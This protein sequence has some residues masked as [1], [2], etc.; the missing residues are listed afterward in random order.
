MVFQ[1][2]VQIFVANGPRELVMANQED[3]DL[4]VTGVQR[5]NATFPLT[6]LLELR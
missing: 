1:N 3:H 4:L 6:C 5:T 2:V